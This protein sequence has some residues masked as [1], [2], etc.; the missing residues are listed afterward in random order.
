[1]RGRSPSWH[2]P[3]WVSQAGKVSDFVGGGCSLVTSI[4]MF[5]KK[6]NKL[7]SF[8]IIKN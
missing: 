2:G 3:L 4:N 7:F 8:I 6:N 1:M 5:K